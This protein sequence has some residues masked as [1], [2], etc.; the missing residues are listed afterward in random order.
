MAPLRFA[1]SVLSSFGKDSSVM[2]RTRTIPDPRLV[3]GLGIL[4]FSAWLALEGVLDTLDH[5]TADRERGGSTGLA[6]TE[7][8]HTILECEFITGCA[9]GIPSLAAVHWHVNPNDLSRIR[10]RVFRVDG[11]SSADTP[12]GR[13]EFESSL[14]WAPKEWVRKAVPPYQTPFGPVTTWNLIYAPMD[15][16][17]FHYFPRSPE[18]VERLRE[19]G[20]YR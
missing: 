1:T 17:W 18:S 13:E 19:A 9:G 5:G 14:R 6:V 20:Y 11:S 10:G 7:R 15:R 12:S 16:V 8:P 4:I 2:T 3:F